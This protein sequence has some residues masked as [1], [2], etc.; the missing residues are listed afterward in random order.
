MTK[1]YI[2]QTG[3]KYHLAPGCPSFADLERDRGRPIATQPRE[4]RGLSQEPCSVCWPR[5]VGY[6]AWRQFELKVEQ[7]GD[8]PYEALFVSKVLRQVP[9]LRP[10]EVAT[11]RSA[12]GRSGSTY[13]LDF[14]ISPPDG[15]RIAV[16]IDGRDKAPGSKTP[17]EVRR[18]VDRKR[19]DLIEAGWR[20]LN[21]TNE[22]VATR[23]D[24]CV[25]E[26]RAELNDAV[27]PRISGAPVAAVAGINGE[28]GMA[29]VDERSASSQ[30]RWLP[31]AL[32]ALAAV[33]VFVLTATQWPR[34]T[35]PV[36]P[37]GGE[38]PSGTPIK[39]N[40][41][42]SGEKIY[43]APGWQYYNKTGAEECFKT[44]EEAEAAG[45]RAS[46]IQ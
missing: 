36:Q 41:S 17:E 22:R 39:G 33:V 4:L 14:V 21:F 25:S 24:Q 31:W 20:I 34:E 42:M 10:S 15:H 27:P 2:T 7:V 26:V 9:G 8:S 38:C 28:A 32:A 40:V 19:A 37:S 46:Q 12:R 13:Y 5:E 23:S 30:R 11:Q 43:H 16:E 45:Y 1:V 6:D 3:T 44:S 35:G 29:P 18:D